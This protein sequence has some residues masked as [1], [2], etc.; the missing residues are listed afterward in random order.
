M[1]LMRLIPGVPSATPAQLNKASTR[2]P[3]SDSAR[4]ME[5]FSARSTE[6]VFTPVR[7]ILLRSMT[8]TSAPASRTTSATAAPIPVAPPTTRARLPRSPNGSN[9]DMS[10]L[11]AQG[12]SGS[13]SL[14]GQALPA[15]H[16][17]G[18]RLDR[19][20]PV[21]LPLG[22]AL[23]HFLQHD[24]AFEP[25]QGGTQAEVNAVAERHVLSRG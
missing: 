21:D 7:L 12:Q 11:L 20:V 17:R 24:A 14:D 25:G 10:S 9:S 6:M 18:V 4:S 3:H 8:T 23:E 1:K 16:R 15:A 19:V 13:R 5:P 2:P 22:E